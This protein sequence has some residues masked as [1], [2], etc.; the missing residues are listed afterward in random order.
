MTDRYIV[1]NREGAPIIHTN[2]L[3][4]AEMYRPPLG[5]VIDT[6]EVEHAA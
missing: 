4:T 6:E 5:K 2:S 3:Q 1:T